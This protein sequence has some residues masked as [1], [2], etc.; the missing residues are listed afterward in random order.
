MMVNPTKR[1]KEISAKVTPWLR[2]DVEKG[3]AYL[4]EGAPGDVKDAWDEWKKIEEEK[5]KNPFYQDCG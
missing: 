4:A 5:S 1:E 3:G 2:Y